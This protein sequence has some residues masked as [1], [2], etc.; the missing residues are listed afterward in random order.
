MQQIVELAG[1]VLGNF[2][3]FAAPYG[4]IL[5][6]LIV[7]HLL[8]AL[9]FQSRRSN[10]LQPP[11]D[12]NAAV[13]ELFFRQGFEVERVLFQGRLSAEYIMTRLGTRAC[14][15]VKWWSKPV[16]DVPVR[17]ICDAQNKYRC[18][19]AILISQEGFTK[20]ARRM[21]RKDVW[22]WDFYSLDEELAHYATDLAAGWQTAAAAKLQ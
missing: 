2:A 3:A 21:K 20:A 13:L 8:G 22:L 11:A 16:A 19:S 10:G 4:T 5:S 6:V 9:W 12:T 17:E 7:L 15:H 14:V 18:E 1:T